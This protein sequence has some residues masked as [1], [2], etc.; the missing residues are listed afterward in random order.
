MANVYH[1]DTL[2]KD[3]NMSDK[4]R[5]R[6]HQENS[7]PIMNE[8]KTWLHA[9]INEKRV[10]PNSGMGKAISYMLRHWDEL[11]LFLRVEKAPID[12]NLCEQALKM[13]IR[14]RKNSLFYKTM[15]GAYIGDLFMSIIHTCNLNN[16]NPL[17]YLVILQKYCSDVLKNPHLW[18]PWN[19]KSMAASA[20]I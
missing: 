7:G 19:Y 15:N 5:L 16:V 2:T 8:L 3:Q 12:N 9:Q 6:F 18:L 4:E 1:H 10:E 14:H 11:T 13:I 20:N 17:D